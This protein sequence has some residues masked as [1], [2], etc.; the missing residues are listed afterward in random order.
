MKRFFA[1]MVMSALVFAGGNAQALIIDNFTTA[2]VITLSVPPTAT[3][4]GTVAGS[5]ILGGTRYLQ[6]TSTYVAGKASTNYVDISSGSMDLFSGGQAAPAVL[7]RW[8]I[9]GGIDLTEGSVNQAIIAD[10]IYSDLNGNLSFTLWD[11]INSSTVSQTGLSAGKAIFLFS[12]FAP[13]LDLTN[14]TKIEMNLTGPANM[15]YGMRLL[16]AAP[17]PEPS[18]LILLGCGLVGAAVIRRKRN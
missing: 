9:A 8:N 6:F 18:T 14:I 10:I 11:G 1:A 3:S 12:A 17:V 4:S 2:Q 5:G 15:D 13:T 16:E 7:T